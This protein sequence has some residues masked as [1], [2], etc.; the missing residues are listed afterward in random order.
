MRG[1]D[2]NDRSQRNYSNV[3]VIIAAFNE[4]QS[5]AEVVRRVFL[6]LPGAEVL[7]VHGG[8]DGT[9]KVVQSLANKLPR[10]RLIP[11]PNDRGK[12][13]AIRVG[14]AH[15]SGEIHAQIDGDLQFLPE[16]LPRLIDPILNH[17]VDITLGSR[18]MPGSVR[19]PGSTPL[20]RTFGNLTAS[21]YASLACGHRI[22]DG[23]AGAKAWSRAAIQQI[24]LKSENY[25]YE[26]E[27]AVKG[28]LCGM[29]VLD[30]PVTT[31]KRFTGISNVNVLINGLRLLWDITRFWY[32][33]RIRQ[34]RGRRTR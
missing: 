9:G 23:Q 26:S 32:E 8:T 20:V 29:R 28:F 2:L 1:N 18:F 31:F 30:I 10:L 15:A 21:F 19:E 22:T 33:G 24:G 5:I 11:N 17:E 7:V 3:S 13:H 34:A 12:G 27:I 14:I 4:E 25:S 16:E 6:S